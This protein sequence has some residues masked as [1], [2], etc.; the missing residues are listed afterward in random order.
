MKKYFAAVIAIAL[1]ALTLVFATISIAQAPKAAPKPV[2]SANAGAIA[3]ANAQIAQIS[4]QIAPLNAKLQAAQSQK[5][6]AKQKA[7][8]A[9]GLDACAFT[10]SPDGKF[11]VP[12]RQFGPGCH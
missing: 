6:I 3:A 8:A 7:L 10:V 2:D 4:A 5:N 11:F 12:Q 9:A 1:V